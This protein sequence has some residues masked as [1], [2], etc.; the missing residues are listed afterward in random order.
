ML[1]MLGSTLIA[2]LRASELRISDRGAFADGAL[3]RHGAAARQYPLKKAGLTALKRPD[4][5]HETGTGNPVLL[6]GC[7]HVGLPE[8][9]RYAARPWALTIAMRS[10][11]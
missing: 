2:W 4:D 10:T 5:C 7:V 11:P 6:I 8:A 9:L 1:A 3:T